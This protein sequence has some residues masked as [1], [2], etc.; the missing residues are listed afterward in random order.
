MS[1]GGFPANRRY[2][3]RFYDATHRTDTSPPYC[4]HVIWHVIARRFVERTPANV[5]IGSAF[6]RSFFLFLFPFLFSFPSTSLLNCSPICPRRT[7]WFIFPL[8]ASCNRFY[9][10]HLLAFGN[11]MRARQRHAAEC[12]KTFTINS[13]GWSIAILEYRSV[14]CDSFINFIVRPR[15]AKVLQPAG[16]LKRVVSPASGHW[17]FLPVICHVE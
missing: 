8:R 13:R 17:I 16:S 1:L 4:F 5:A 10:C 12:R 9:Y 14:F 3:I 7:R 2:E 6:P 11:C 15:F